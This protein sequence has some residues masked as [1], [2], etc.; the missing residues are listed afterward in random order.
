MRHIDPNGYWLS[1]GRDIGIRCFPRAGSTSIQETYGRGGN[2][3]NF[4]IMPK[5]VCVV[6]DPWERLMSVWY[7]MVKSGNFKNYG[8]VRDGLDSLPEFLDWLIDRD[9]FTQDAHITAQWAFLKGWWEPKDGELMTMEDFFESPPFSL[10]RIAVH[11][12]KTEYPQDIAIPRKAYSRWFDALGAKDYEL[13]ERA[14]KSPLVAGG[15]Q[16]TD[17]VRP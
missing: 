15:K 16:A 14:Q 11:K 17:D 4:A 8:F 1:I 6:R 5:K 13:Y 3:A 12:N 7:G 10:Q 9:P 2:F